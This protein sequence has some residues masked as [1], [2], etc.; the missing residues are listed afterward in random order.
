LH[1]VQGEHD[2][3]HIVVEAPFEPTNRVVNSRVGLDQALTSEL[4]GTGV[5]QRVLVVDAVP[6][7]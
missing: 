7:E 3:R 1:A 2:E 5:M 4:R 6:A